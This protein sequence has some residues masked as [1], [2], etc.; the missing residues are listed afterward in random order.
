M[1]TALILKFVDVP[2]IRTGKDSYLKKGYVETEGIPFTL[3]DDFGR[4]SKLD[5]VIGVKIKKKIPSEI[6]VR[7]RKIF[8]I[9]H[10]LYRTEGSAMV[11]YDPETEAFDVFV[12]KQKVSAAHVHVIAEEINKPYDN[13][14]LVAAFFHSHPFGGGKFLSG[15]DHANACNLSYV[16]IGSFNFPTSKLSGT[17]DRS[18]YAFGEIESEFHRC[19]LDERTLADFPEIVEITADEEKELKELVEA[20][21]EREFVMDRFGRKHYGNKQHTTKKSCRHTVQ[22]RDKHEHIANIFGVTV[23]DLKAMEACSRRMQPHLGGDMDYDPFPD[24][25]RNPLD[26]CSE[27]FQENY[28]EATI[29]EILMAFRAEPFYTKIA[30]AVQKGAFKDLT[31]EEVYCFLDG[32]NTGLEDL[33]LGGWEFLYPEDLFIP[34]DPDQNFEEGNIDLDPPEALESMVSLVVTTFKVLEIIYSS[35]CPPNDPDRL[36]TETILDVVNYLKNTFGVSPVFEIGG[37]HGET[38]NNM[39]NCLLMYYKADNKLPLPGEKKK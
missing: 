37:T 3:R 18:V 10:E 38:I 2:E 27:P 13:K 32:V 11:T 20:A 19:S 25:C 1:A 8:Q 39:L 34:T 21:V 5:P 6:M 4:L 15:T 9:F 33:N 12:P 22:D 24:S 16:P 7:V 23:D 31:P 14:L 28:G 29:L 36:S 17:K 26:D 35:L 30:K